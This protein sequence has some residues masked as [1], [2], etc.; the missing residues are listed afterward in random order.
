MYKYDLALSFAGE[1]RHLAATFA[2]RLDASGYSIFYD[3]FN[4][5]ELWGRDL[6]VVLAKIYAE[7]ARYCL[8]ILSHEYLQKPWTNHER[9]SSISEFINKRGDY[10][11]CLKVDEVDLPGYSSVM[12]YISLKRYSEDEVYQLLLQKLGRPNHANQLSRLDVNDTELAARVIEACFR[13]AIYSRM[14]SEINLRAMYDSI[15]KAIGILLNITPKIHDQALQFTCGEI[16]NALDEIDR[17]QTQ[18]SEGISN[19]LEPRLRML[20]DE[21]KQKVVRLL[22]EIRRAAGIPMQ[23]PFALR[24]DH[25]FSGADEAPKADTQ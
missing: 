13:R 3:E 22:L 23:L 15:G 5:S 21:N 16:I 17:V 7:Q 20:I 1:Q 25:F 12:G 2:Q 24:T 9:R 6:S 4:Q 18:S 8:I 19:H 14:D 10:I 11:L